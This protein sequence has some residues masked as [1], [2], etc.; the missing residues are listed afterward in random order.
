MSMF[1][2]KFFESVTKRYVFVGFEI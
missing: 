2:A 1:L